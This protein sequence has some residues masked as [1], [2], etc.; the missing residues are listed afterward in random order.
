M[1]Q[2]MVIQYKTRPD[3]NIQDNTIP[4]NTKQNHIRQ[5]KATNGKTIQHTTL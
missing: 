4:D 5:E 2:D 3:N 1:I